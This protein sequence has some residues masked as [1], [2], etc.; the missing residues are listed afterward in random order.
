[1]LVM[2]HIVAQQGRYGCTSDNI[3]GT[4]KTHHCSQRRARTSC[5]IA[6]SSGLIPEEKAALSSV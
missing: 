4:Q 5:K 3:G 6:A 2:D 1:M